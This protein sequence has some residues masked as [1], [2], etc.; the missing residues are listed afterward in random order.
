MTAQAATVMERVKD[1]EA[2][3]MNRQDILSQSS[4]TFELISRRAFEICESRGFVPGHE[5]EDWLR[6]ESELLHPIPLG[7]FESVDKYVVQAE[8]PGFR[9]RDLE[10][11]AEPRRLVIAGLRDSN[12]ER[13]NGQVICSELRADRLLRAVDLPSG[14]DTSRVSTTL[15]DGILTVELPKSGNAE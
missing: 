9:K 14:V 13:K 10:I 8:V 4:E 5:K 6:A 7:L 2:V 3:A 15:E 12:L 11:T 1:T